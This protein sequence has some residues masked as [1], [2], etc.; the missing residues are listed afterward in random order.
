MAFSMSIPL[1]LLGAGVIAALTYFRGPKIGLRAHSEKHG[2]IRVTDVALSFS[3]WR[4][5][6]RIDPAAAG[7]EL[8]IYVTFKT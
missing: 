4:R 2:P 6:G 8:V 7:R 3:P 1:Y 5:R